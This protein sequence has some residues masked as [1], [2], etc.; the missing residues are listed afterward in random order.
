MTP[1]PSK[2]IQNIDSTT[3]NYKIYNF[4]RKFRIKYNK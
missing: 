1:W 4:Q 3:N 2:Q